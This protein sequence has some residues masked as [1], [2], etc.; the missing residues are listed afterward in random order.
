MS[1]VG[2]DFGNLQSK[3]AVARNR[4][5][6]VICNEVSNRATPSLV[7]FGNKN[8]YLGEAAKTQEI[9]NFKNTVGSLKRLAGRSFQDKEIHEIE[10]KYI[11]ADFVDERGQV[12]VKVQYLDEERVFTNTQLVAMY[13]TKLKDITSVELKIPVSDV[14]ISVPGWFTDVQRR[15]VLD[16]AE[17]AGLNCLRLLNDTTAAALGY[18]ITKTDL[19][20]DK[21]RNVVFVDIG[22]S[23]Y[24]VTIVSFVK[25]QLTVKSTAYDRHL[26]GR[27]FDEVLVNH[28]VEV[29]KEKY[30]IDIRSNP[31]AL[32]RLRTGV[33]K[34]KKVLSANTQA[35]L[36]VESIMN[37]IDVS[38]IISRQE[39]EEL[40]Q[41][42]L[43]RI[44]IP[45]AQALQE[46]GLS[47]ED[48]HS[49]EVV[50]GSTRIPSVKE[51][52]SKFFGQELKYTLNQDE[53]VAR[54]CALQCAILSPVFKV[55][56]FTV[57]DITT[58]P[59]KITWEKIPE[60][61]DEESELVVYSKYNSIPST[62]I[63]TFYRKQQFDI[64]AYYAEP[65]KLP[66]G[67]SPWIGKFSIKQVEPTENGDLSIV[68]VKSRLNVHGVLSIENAHV[69]E[70][71]IK[72]EKEEV[73]ESQP[74]D[75]DAK[76]EEASKPAVKKVKKLM[77][78]GDLPVISVH[79]G[80]D[81]AVITQYKELEAQ[82][83]VSDKL[84]A[85]TET[86]KNALEEYVYDIRSKVET[87][88]SEFV[89]PAIK[90]T[91]V[92]LL[93]ET[94]EW[95]YDE[96]ED[97]TKSI[98]SE[99]L[100]QLK[101][102]GVPIVERYREA[103][104]LPRAENL[105]R[106]SISSFILNATSNDERF[107][108]I[109]EEEKKSIVEKANKISE[110]LNEKLATQANVP[111][112]QLPAVTSREILK[113]RENLVHFASPILSKPKPKPEPESKPEETPT[114]EPKPEETPVPDAT[115]ENK[116]TETPTSEG[117]A[118]N[119]EPR[120]EGNP[121]NENTSKTAIKALLKET[122]SK[123]KD[124]PEVT[125]EIEACK[126]LE[127]VLSYAFYARVERSVGAEG[128]RS[129]NLT[130][131]PI[132]L[133]AEDQYYVWFYEGSQL[134]NYLG[135]FVLIGAVFAGVL[136]PL[137]PVMLRNF[138]WYISVF[139]LSL[140][141]VLILII[142]IRPVLFFLSMVVI[143]PGIWLFPNLLADVG[144]I[145]SFIP[146]WDWEVPN[147]KEKVPDNDE[148]EEI[149]KEDAEGIKKARDLRTTVE[150]DKDDDEKKND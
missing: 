107:A 1:V 125:S 148:D 136:F 12:A 57:Q 43:N 13:F 70:E 19:P 119:E 75:T 93:N 65:D 6:D 89:D 7:S 60:I 97:S 25:G 18:G 66:T 48:I 10:K 94:E 38:A 23:S 4:G 87:T 76:P 11:N 49:V 128:S 139:I 131:N 140:F 15:S 133:W 102:Y 78:K 64:E 86:Q 81:K 35:P 108:H 80:L 22:H 90:E 142:A 103:E 101:K 141:G 130:I 123:K 53:A 74:M 46:S 9:S 56:E 88:Y 41:H 44:E 30:K 28:F 26:G 27:N 29:F 69:V 59:V 2:I 110:W 68:K 40:S 134:L 85:D 3:I 118:K 62:K 113:E 104:D 55:R 115:S 83:V 100:D 91:F 54:G 126:V 79:G 5:I 92:K 145:D 146:L 16:A 114:S 63:L 135:G 39:F 34:L 109:P 77:K 52:I 116:S 149:H 124:V 84:V 82:M 61:P 73:S 17:I 144:F 106:E 37:D 50:G 36:N 127:E 20:E 45:L 129:K 33:E 21:P 121:E 58:Y 95:L 147:K 51:R 8:R 122:Y 42:I 72:E 112:Y 32:F 143:P 67:I 71:I 132:Q 47:L 31:R 138:V 120:S 111:K 150:D 24:S 98:Y 14:V 99:K 137:W 96:G 117:D 105:L